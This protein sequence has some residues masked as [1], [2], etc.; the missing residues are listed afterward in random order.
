MNNH[1]FKKGENIVE[2]E[3]LLVLH[4]CPIAPFVTLLSISRLLQIRQNASTCW[5][6]FI[7]LLELVVTLDQ[8]VQIQLQMYAVSHI[9]C[10]SKH[11]SS[12]LCAGLFDL[13]IFTLTYN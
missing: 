6:G 7:S 13:K 5:I 1:Y 11:G 8:P 10:L 9:E 12:A 2:K 3:K 4:N